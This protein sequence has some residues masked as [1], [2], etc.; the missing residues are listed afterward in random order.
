MALPVSTMQRVV[1]TLLAHGKM[2]RGYLGVAAQP[3]RLPE[4][5]AEQLGQK[6]G[7]LLISVTSGSPA[8]KAGLLLG[9]TLV[10]LDDQPVRHMDDLMAVLGSD[11]IEQEA[12]VR[13][14]RGGEIQERR[15]IIG[16]RA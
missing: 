16:A 7:L 11:R 12:S 2:R 3:V 15:V 10:A 6:S 8:E 14:V 4:D 1:E 9:D 13:F 5:V